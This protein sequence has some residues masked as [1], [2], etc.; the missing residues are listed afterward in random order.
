MSSA[1]KSCAHSQQAEQACPSTGITYCKRNGSGIQEQCRMMA[2]RQRVSCKGKRWSLN[3]SVPYLQIKSVKGEDC[4]C[5]SIE[6]ETATPE[7]FDLSRFQASI[8]PRI[9]IQVKVFGSS[10]S[11][12]PGRWAVDAPPVARHRWESKKH[13][14]SFDVHCCEACLVLPPRCRDP[15]VGY[16][17]P[18]ILKM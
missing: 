10:P 18:S 7:C 1:R 17:S 9:D 3:S 11:I 4:C 13:E 16:R 8:C 12:V 14:F 15:D 5:Y 2:A 6:P